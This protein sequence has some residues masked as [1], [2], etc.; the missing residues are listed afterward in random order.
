M[1]VFSA[2]LFSLALSLGAV[3]LFSAPARAQS[4]SN[5]AVSKEDQEEMRRQ[6]QTL[7]DAFEVKKPEAKAEQKKEQPKKTVAD[8]A[9]RALSMVEN[10]TAQLSNTLSKVAPEVWRIMIRQQYAKAAM[11]TIVPLGTLFAIFIV[12]AYIRKYW[13]PDNGD[14]FSDDDEKW[15]YIWVTRIIPGVLL[16][17]NG[18]WLFNRMSDAI[19]YLI[20]PEYYAIQDLLRMLLTR[21]AQ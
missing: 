4:E 13:R 18:L 20:N 3:S 8:V 21:T 12:V 17:L 9:D 5:N 15:G 10:V 6:L 2:L 16:L 1:K 11:A 19:A 14:T 7:A